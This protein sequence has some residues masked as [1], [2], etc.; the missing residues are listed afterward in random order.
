MRNVKVKK[1]DLM[2]ILRK[3]RR[4]HKQ[5][6]QQAQEKYRALVIKLL[7]EELAK[8]K[9]GNPFNIQT[10]TRVQLPQDH[11]A[12]YDLEI[13][14][15]DMSV[16]QEI[17][18]DVHQFNSFVNDEWEWSRGWAMSNAHYTD[19]GAKYQKFLND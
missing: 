15:L 18:L 12:D 16:D 2:E 5:V 8:A 14:M 9:A 7:D 3:N 10:I 13:Q 6:V 4:D 11:T 19:V 1:Q 17:V